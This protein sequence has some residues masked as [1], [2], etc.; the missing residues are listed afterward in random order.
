[1]KI[2]LTILFGFLAVA[3]KAA[4]S[5]GQLPAPPAGTAWKLV[6]HDE[7][8]GHK[9]DESKWEA[10]DHR[11]RDGWWSPQAVSLDGNGH[12]AISTLQDGDRY[13]DACVRT[14]G[15]FEHAHGYYAARIKLQ[16]QPGHW[17]AFWLYHA[18]VGRI[19][20]AGRDGTEIE[21]IAPI[22]PLQSPIV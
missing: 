11:R 1:M 7:F 2:A 9:L 22:T 14:R 20:E 21:I 18:S 12:L 5:D 13:L 16:E 3:A 6:W 17:S 4:E 15:K 8:D 19:G 10:P